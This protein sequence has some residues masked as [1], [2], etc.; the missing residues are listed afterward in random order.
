MPSRA[1]ID[2]FELRDHLGYLFLLDVVGQPARFRYRLIGTHITATVG[3]DSTGRFVDE[4]YPNRDGLDLTEFYRY[5]TDA[6][7][8]ARNHGTVRWVDKEHKRYEAVTLPLSEDGERVNMFLG[9]MAFSVE[10]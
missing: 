10:P 7:C 2:P 1:D 5:L 4:A 9:E 3:R 8:P 6:K